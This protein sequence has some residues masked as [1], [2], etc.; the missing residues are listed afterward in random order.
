[1]AQGDRTGI[2]AFVPRRTFVYMDDTETAHTIHEG[3]TYMCPHGMDQREAM[4]LAK[5]GE[6]KIL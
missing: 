5:L 6:G 1:M 4:E 3:V 2:I